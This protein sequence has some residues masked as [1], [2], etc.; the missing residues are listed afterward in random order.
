MSNFRKFYLV[1]LVVMSFITI[2]LESIERSS[3]NYNTTE[4]RDY[5][6]HYFEDDSP[7]SNWY[8][9]ESW[10]VKFIAS[11]FNLAASEMTI[12]KVKIYFPTPSTDGVNIRAYTYDENSI[13]D[14]QEGTEV[15][16]LNV[17]D[18][19][20][21]EADWYEFTLTQPY[22]GEGLW[23]VIDKETNYQD[24]FMATRSGNG[25]N[26]YY[27]VVDGS[28]A[29]FRSF[30]DVQIEQELLVKVFAT[31]ELE[32]STI[33]LK[34]VSVNHL[35]DNDWS[36][37]YQ[38]Y[39]YSDEVIDNDTLLVT[40]SHPDSEIFP[41]SLYKFNPVLQ[42]ESLNENAGNEFIINLPIENSQFKINI[43]L[44][45]ASDNTIYGSKLLLVD[46]FNSYDQQVHIFNMM[47][48]VY[49]FT[50]LILETQRSIAES[51][52]N[53]IN[54]G[55]DINDPLFYSNAA[56]N[57]YNDYGV[58]SFPM[59]IIN[60]DTY[61]TGYN[62]ESIESNLVENSYNIKQLFT[63]ITDSLYSEDGIISFQHYFNYGNKYVFDSFT[64]NLALKV[65]LLQESKHYSDEG[66]YFIVQELDDVSYDFERLL[67]NEEAYVSVNY[68]PNNVDTLQT[69][70]NG[71]MKSIIYIYNEETF[72]TVSV[73]EYSFENNI[74]VSND[75]SEVIPSEI[76]KFYPNPCKSGKY[77]NLNSNRNDIEKVNI[78]NIRGQ[79]IETVNVD[80]NGIKIPQKM[81][82]GV[83]LLRPIGKNGFSYK[84]QKSVI[85]K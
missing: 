61:Y 8:G 22:T 29:Y 37:N 79:K 3:I 21:N 62:I 60:G 70:S 30:A 13:S 15:L 77:L 14:P 36:I 25:Q 16:D 84:T 24:E 82:S 85:I 59:T 55:V 75:N 12:E 52:W 6:L 10:A 35:E 46:N 78:Y 54:F 80:A 39:N 71:P 42:P 7:T 73:T 26:S 33:E 81:A 9:A 5:S 51:N 72:Q 47:S 20:I 50:D 83:Y 23:I 31:L 56:F 66:D 19:E 28:D 27:K 64:N 76:I 2:N 49:P 17:Q 45:K 57:Y 32:E 1:L 43:Q 74:F 58:S 40:I 48:S 53:I 41:D 38:I 4:V 69:D 63:T 11:D 18:F 65:Y 68:D 67:T 34:D 44:K